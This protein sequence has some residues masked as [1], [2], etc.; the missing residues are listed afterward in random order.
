MDS[1]N[2]TV[3]KTEFK[4]VLNDAGETS[5]IDLNLES[6][7]H[8]VLVKD[9]QYDPI[10]LDFMHIGF[11][12]P[13]L[14]EEISADIPVEYVGEE[15]IPLVKS[16]DALFLAVVDTIE[17]KALPTDLPKAFVVDVSKLVEVGDSI[18]VAD[19]VYNKEKIEIVGLEEDDLLAKLDYAEMEEEEVEVTEEEAVAGIEAT[20]ETAEEDEEDTEDDK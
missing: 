4:R 12:K 6:N 19:L 14:T 13:N 7:N 15:N 10:S 9:V 20:E 18:T 16:K 3:G 5:L 17:V 11:Y 8:K 2:I 1:I